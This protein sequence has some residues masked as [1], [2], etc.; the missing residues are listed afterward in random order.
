MLEEGDHQVVIE[1]TRNVLA[2]VVDR[3]GGLPGA[4]L[5]A[6]E[7]L[8]QR[9]V[10]GEVRHADD[11]ARETTAE[12]LLPV[13]R[14]AFRALREETRGKGNIATQLVAFGAGDEERAVRIAEEAELP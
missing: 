6:L 13:L 2:Q 1:I 8:L 9:L 11:D 5:S 14:S 10:D 3:P 12:A 4:A 7:S